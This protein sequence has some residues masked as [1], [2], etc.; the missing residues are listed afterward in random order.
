MNGRNAAYWAGAL[1]LLLGCVWMV[2]AMWERF[3]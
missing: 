1:L 3:G 2:L